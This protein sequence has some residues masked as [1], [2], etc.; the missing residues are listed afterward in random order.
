MDAEF[1]C[2]NQITFDTLITLLLSPFRGNDTPASLY[3]HVLYY[4]SRRMATR[5]S[6]AQGT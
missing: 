2:L 3:Q 1:V 6:V 5:L 4:A